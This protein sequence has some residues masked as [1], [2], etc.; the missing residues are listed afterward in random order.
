MNEQANIKK[1]KVFIVGHEGT[2]GLRIGERLAARQDIELI[3]IADEKRKDM[4]AILAGINQAEIVYLC[5][6]DAAAKEIIEAAKEAEVTAKF[7]DTSTAHRTHPQ[8]A[9]GFPELSKAHRGSIAYNQY[10]AVP[11][12]HASGVIALTA[13]LVEAGILPADYPLN[14]LSLTGYSGGGKKMIAEYEQAKSERPVALQAPRQYA[15][16]QVHKHLK[17]IQH[18][19]HLTAPLGFSPIVADYYSGMEVTIH[20]QTAHLAKPMTAEAIWQVY[21]AKF[22]GSPVV[23][24]MPWAPETTNTLFL[25]ANQMS[26]YDDMLIYVSGHDD[27]VAVHAVFDNLGKGASGAA[28]QCMNIMLGLEETTSLVLSDFA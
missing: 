3:P 9:Y 21:K 25:A 14:A 19:C 13:P 26:G 8:W 1:H 2:T 6:P 10:V 12:C 4:D 23:K 27:R 24:V 28:V 18:Q 5:L 17:E 20:L 22:E 7:L 16:G 15:L 11:G